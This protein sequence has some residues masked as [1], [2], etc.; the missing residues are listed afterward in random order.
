MQI[1]YI[2]PAGGPV[3]EDAPDPGADTREELSYRL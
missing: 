1:V 3:S 2:D